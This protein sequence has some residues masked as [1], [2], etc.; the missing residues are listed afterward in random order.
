MLGLVERKK[1]GFLDFSPDG[2]GSSGSSVSIQQIQ[3]SGDPIADITVGEET[4]RLFAPE[5]GGL[6]F[7]K[8]GETVFAKIGTTTIYA[9][10]ISAPT[11]GYNNPSW[12]T[13]VGDILGFLCGSWTSGIMTGARPLGTDGVSITSCY[14]VQGSGLYLTYSGSGVSLKNLVFLYTK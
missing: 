10:H 1:D 5:S 8:D 13:E 9:G 11:S 6:E 7:V 4:T 12:L 2:G 14:Y 3:T